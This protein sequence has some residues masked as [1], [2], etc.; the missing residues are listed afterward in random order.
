MKNIYNFFLLLIEAKK[1]VLL[2]SHVLT[3]ILTSLS[4][5]FQHCFQKRRASFVGTERVKKAF[6][7][8][9]VVV[10]LFLAFVDVAVCFWGW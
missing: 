4:W 2:L 3:I 10:L 5:N 8:I 9:L 6:L 1:G 7:D